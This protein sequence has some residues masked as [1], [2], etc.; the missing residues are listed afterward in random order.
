MENPRQQLTE[1]LFLGL[2]DRAPEAS[3]CFNKNIP[4]AI[5]T[6][7]VVSILLQTEVSAQSGVTKMAAVNFLAS[8][9][10]Q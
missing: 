6:I 3:H 4:T 2:Q 10:K 7:D 8:K 5:R 1:P 9:M